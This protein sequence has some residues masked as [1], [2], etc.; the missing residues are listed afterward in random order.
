MRLEKIRRGNSI[1]RQVKYSSFGAHMRSE[2]TDERER[3][4][5]GPRPKE[6]P[7]AFREKRE[8]TFAGPKKKKKAPPTPDSISAMTSRKE[9]YFSLS[10]ESRD[11]TDLERRPRVRGGKQKKGPEEGKR[12]GG[13]DAQKGNIPVGRSRRPSSPESRKK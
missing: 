4:K 3:K 5:P 13:G 8:G 2:E 6:T 11:G 1:S 10:A 9:G 12:Q 7:P